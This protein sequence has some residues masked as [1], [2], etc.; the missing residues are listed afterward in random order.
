MN[1]PE[2]AASNRT[3]DHL[4]NER[5]FLAWV[6][7]SL[8]LIGLGFV[9]ARMGLFL[10]QLAAASLVRESHRLRFQAGHEFLISGV[11]ILLAGIAI[12]GWAARRYRDNRKA[13]D[14]DRFEPAD[15]SVLVITA[16]VVIGGLLIAA[17]VVWRTL[18]TSES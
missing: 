5:T 8:G 12:C 7:T 15:T 14:R 2:P 16:L 13:I 1:P 9:L 3:R 6:R 18:G 10:R 17:M 4:A 11:L